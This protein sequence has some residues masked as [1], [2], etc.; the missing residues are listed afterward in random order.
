MG[1]KFNVA[2]LPAAYDDLDEIF[3]YILLDNPT[4]AESM[5][6]NI[7]ASLHRLED[8]P[9]SGV[10]LIAK[11]LKHYDFRM[12]I[13]DPYIAFYRLIDNQVL[14]YRILHGNRDYI[15]LLKQ[16]E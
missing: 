1:K 2:L 7:M 3:D 16:I 14:I 10:K 4:A 6:A 13:T 11:S 5:L 9:N 8:F 15:R 12:V